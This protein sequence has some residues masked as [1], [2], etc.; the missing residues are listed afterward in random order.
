MCASPG[1]LTSF[2]TFGDVRR[3]LGTVKGFGL[4]APLA[5]P[6]PAPSARVA[7]FCSG[8]ELARCGELPAEAQEPKDRS[9]VH[10]APYQ[11]G[12]GAAREKS[13]A[14]LQNH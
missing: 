10:P 7:R 8:N 12:G 11:G 1:S 13:A 14:F 9:K 2:W 6:L 5:R 4:S 3:K